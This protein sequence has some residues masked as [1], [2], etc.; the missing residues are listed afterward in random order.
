[1]FSDYWWEQYRAEI[2][3]ATVMFLVA[4]I[5]T[6]MLRP[7]MPNATVGV[8]TALGFFAAIFVRKPMHSYMERFGFKFDPDYNGTY[9]SVWRLAWAT[10]VLIAFVIYLSFVALIFQFSTSF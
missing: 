4:L 9:K 8:R 10:A 7:L 5:L 6:A 2:I 1:M 3:P